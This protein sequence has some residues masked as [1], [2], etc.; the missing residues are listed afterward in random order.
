MAIDIK[1]W[2][3]VFQGYYKKHG[4]GNNTAGDYKVKVEQANVKK[5]ETYWACI[6]VRHLS[7]SENSGNHHVYIDVL[8]ENGKRV[9]GADI[10]KYSW[11]AD[12]AR[13]DKPANEA[14][15]NIPLWKG[16]DVEVRVIGPGNDK[17]DIVRGLNSGHPDEDC[18]NNG[19]TLFHHSF[20]IVFKKVVNGGSSGEEVVEVDKPSEIGPGVGQPGDIVNTESM[21]FNINKYQ[22]D[23]VVVVKEV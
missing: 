5:G 19:N 1:H 22:I 2:N 17:S 21:T 3:Q 13:V 20:Y 18:G 7:C 12:Y 9:N 8:D 11:K 14:G 10:R 23:I 15:T 6:G 16:E 4:R